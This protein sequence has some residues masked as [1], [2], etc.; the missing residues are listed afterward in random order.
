MAVALGRKD[1]STVGVEPVDVE[2]EGRRLFARFDLEERLDTL[3]VAI[4]VLLFLQISKRI[5][6]VCVQVCGWPDWH[7][8]VPFLLRSGVAVFVEEFLLTVDVK[9]APYP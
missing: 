4:S 5:L 7:H 9:G 3:A 2:K 6:Q 1:P 8:P